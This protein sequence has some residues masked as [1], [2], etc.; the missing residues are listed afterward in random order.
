MTG[1][2]KQPIK[3]ASLREACVEEALRIIEADG[4][5]QLS[6]REVARRLGVSHQAPYRHFESRDHILAEAVGRAFSRFAAHLEGRVRHDDP[7]RDLG[8]LGAAYIAFALRHP[9]HYRLMFGAPLPVAGDAA[10]L[11]GLAEKPFAILRGVIRRFPGKE[12]EED[13]RR[14]ALFAWTAVHGLASI[15]QTRIGTAVGLHAEDITEVVAHDLRRIAR[16][17]SG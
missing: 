3:P 11:P 5:E 4:L 1:G 12:D 17:V 15:L 14:D 8:S 13:V 2:D 7:V 16:A 9:S 6:L 10:G